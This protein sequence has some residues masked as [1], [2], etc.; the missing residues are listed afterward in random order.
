MIVF[1]YIY[2][3]NVVR[4]SISR[5]KMKRKFFS[6]TQSMNKIEKEKKHQAHD[7]QMSVLFCQMSIATYYVEEELNKYGVLKCTWVTS[8]FYAFKI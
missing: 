3:S 7:S 1:R 8:L 2:S 6:I 4:D 5:K